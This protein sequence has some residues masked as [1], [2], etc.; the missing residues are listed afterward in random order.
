MYCCKISKIRKK[1]HP[2]THQQDAIYT[3][4]QLP[5]YTER[6][7]LYSEQMYDSKQI[8]ETKKMHVWFRTGFEILRFLC[9]FMASD[10][11]Q[12]VENRVRII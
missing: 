11:T 6:I 2:C 4:K 5:L 8:Q 7:C 10:V 3:F 1:S 12:T 9:V